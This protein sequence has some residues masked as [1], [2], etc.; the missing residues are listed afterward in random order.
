MLQ[1]KYLEIFKLSL[2][3]E[4]KYAYLLWLD[5]LDSLKMFILAL[6]ERYETLYIRIIYFPYV[7]VREGIAIVSVGPFVC[8]SA[9]IYQQPLIQFIEFLY[10]R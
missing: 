3:E 5:V 7:V 2:L 4:K 6:C 8:L 1:I 9:R 10:T